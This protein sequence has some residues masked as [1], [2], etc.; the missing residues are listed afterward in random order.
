MT[1]HEYAWGICYAFSVAFPV[2]YVA[3]MTAPALSGVQGLFV[4][5][6]RNGKEEIYIH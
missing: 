1:S 5:G 4:F 6:E 2:A 3:S